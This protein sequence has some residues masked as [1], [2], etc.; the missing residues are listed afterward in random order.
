MTDVAIRVQNPCP[1]R[2]RRVSKQYRI[3][4]QQAR[5]KTPWESLA[6]YRQALEWQPGEAATRE[7]I[8][9]VTGESE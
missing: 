5:P 2:S 3:D 9:R 1:E 4:A 6:A 8:E 7:Q